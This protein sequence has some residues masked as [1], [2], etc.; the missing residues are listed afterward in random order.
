MQEWFQ[1]FSFSDQFNRY[2]V[3]QRNTG[4]LVLSEFTGAARCLSGARLVNPFSKQD[5]AGAIAEALKTP[6]EGNFI[7]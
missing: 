1:Q 2:V 4:V 7:I 5:I 6:E 3:C